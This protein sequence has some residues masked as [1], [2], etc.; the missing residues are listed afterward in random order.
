M[1]TRW[2]QILNMNLAQPPPTLTPAFTWRRHLANAMAT[3]P[4]T[5]PAA[6]KIALRCPSRGA[7]SA[8][9]WLQPAFNA[10]TNQQGYTAVDRSLV[11]QACPDPVRY[12]R[13]THQGS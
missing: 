6:L 2:R 9:R 11:T 3:H 8:A 12:S 7:S 5:P 4:P 10:V 1:L 13:G